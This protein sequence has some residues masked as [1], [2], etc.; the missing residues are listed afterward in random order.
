MTPLRFF[1]GSLVVVSLIAIGCAGF[2]RSESTDLTRHFA[3]SGYEG[4]TVVY[5]V[6]QDRFTIV[7]P[8]RADKALLPASTFKIFNAMVA[9]D[10]PVI[11]DENEV[12]KWDGKV[13]QNDAWNRDHDLT[14][15]MK[16]SCF[17]Y[18]QELAR[19]IG[20]ER[21]QQWLERTNYGNHKA[22]PAIDRFWLDG[23]LRIS[24]RQQV[25]F[26]SRL[27]TW[28]LPFSRRAM[29]ITKRI[30]VNER[31][32]DYTLYAKTGWAQN[33]AS[34]GWWVGWIERKDGHIY[35]FATNIESASPDAG[36]GEARIRITKDILKD[37]G[38]LPRVE[39]VKDDLKPE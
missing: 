33:P 1:L 15:A 8:Q 36:F 7:N 31:T 38:I 21:M 23:D 25:Q 3:D 9:L 4:T 27:A 11:R 17:P 20:P 26:L 19:R 37:M 22:T 12:I 24:A 14:S 18:F 13:R 2:E 28:D 10:A 29:E 35:V 39:M 16:T 32:S 5:D 30:L 6:T 34:V